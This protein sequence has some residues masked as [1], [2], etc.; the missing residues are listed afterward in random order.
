MDKDRGK[1]P[2]M[3]SVGTRSAMVPA[4]GI[5][6]LSP[7]LRSGR[8][9][10]Y[11]LKDNAVQLPPLLSP[12]QRS[13]LESTIRIAVVPELVHRHEND[14]P[15]LTQDDMVEIDIDGM[16]SLLLDRDASSFK[17]FQEEIDLLREAPAHVFD[18]FVRSVISRVGDMWN[19][20][21]AGFY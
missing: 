9:V 6:R 17:L 12:A 5:F 21:T 13:R 16:V 11:F 7:R 20:D 15:V 2:S 8:F 19:D 14:P 1:Q 3:P 18:Q 10:R 4:S